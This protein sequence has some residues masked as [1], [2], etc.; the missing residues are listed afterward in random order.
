MVPAT[1]E[2]R[3]RH[4]SWRVAALLTVSVIGAGCG[5][6]PT[7]GFLSPAAAPAAAAA[8]TSPAAP[9]PVAS[10]SAASAM[11]PCTLLT[12]AEVSAA[13]GVVAGQGTTAADPRQCT[14]LPAAAGPP[15]QQASVT[16]NAATAL[17]QLC[18]ATSTGGSTPVQGVGDA[19][20]FAGIGGTGLA[21][22]LAAQKGAQIFTVSVVLATG[23]PIPTIEAT[24]KTLALAILP[25]L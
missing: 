11:D 12:Q 20:C 5:S 3:R 7:G 10:Q 19:A 1:A 15:G 21:T 22:Y 14:W 17:S 24:E 25:R 23:T 9:A 13:L 8:S 4:L 2:S 6:A 16:I 18:A